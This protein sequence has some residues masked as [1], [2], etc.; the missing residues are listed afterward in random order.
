MGEVYGLT[1]SQAARN[2]L[3]DA[4]VELAANTAQF[5]GHLRG[6]RG[7]RGRQDGPAGNA[8]APGRGVD[9][10]D[11]RPGRDHAPGGRAGTAGC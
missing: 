2:V 5:L 10:V 3:R 7:A 6:Q 11:R 8:A 4:G 9:D 1:T